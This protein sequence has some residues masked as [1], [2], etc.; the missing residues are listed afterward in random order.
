MHHEDDDPNNALTVSHTVVHSWDYKSLK[1]SFVSQP[2]Q[3][4]QD[5]LLHFQQDERFAPLIA[6][7][8]AADDPTLDYTS[9]E[10]QEIVSGIESLSADLGYEA[11]ARKHV[12]VQPFSEALELEDETLFADGVQEVADSEVA[13]VVA[14]DWE[15][16]TDGELH[17]VSNALFASKTVVRP[18]KFS[19]IGPDV[20]PDNAVELV[21]TTAQFKNW[22]E[23][24]R[25]SPS[26]NL[27]VRTVDGLRRVVKWAAKVGKRVRVAGFRHSWR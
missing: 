20:Q 19:E 6:L 21:E 5:L 17:V 11:P 27:V 22:G 8:A 25:F 7:L 10:V 3:L 12:S 9:P 23:T 26:H 24:V 4:K 14:A 2:A 13:G 15:E 16:D 18:F 1:P